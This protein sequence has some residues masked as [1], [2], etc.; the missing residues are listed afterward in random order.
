MVY[1]TVWDGLNSKTT[2]QD[3]TG[4]SSRPG[5]RRPATDHDTFRRL[6]LSSKKST[7]Q[8]PPK[9]E[10]AIDYYNR[11]V[12]A[13]RAGDYTHAVG[14]FD[15]A[16]AL[17]PDVAA[18]YVRRAIARYE[19]GDYAGA[20]ADNS[21][22]IRLKPNDPVAYHNRGFA[23]AQTGN[24]RAAIAD[25]DRAIS[26]KS[27]YANAYRNRGKARAYELDWEGA[28][29]DYLVLVEHGVSDAEVFSWLGEWSSALGRH[30]DALRYLTR[31]VE[32]EPGSA[33]ILA[34]RAQAY[35]RAGNRAAAEADLA[36]AEAITE[37]G[38]ALD[39]GDTLY[40]K[41]AVAAL[42]GRPRAGARSPVPGSGR[43]LAA[44]PLGGA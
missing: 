1:C 4:R 22:A 20:V 16:I 19:L 6:S 8:V 17:A 42:D 31:A 35:A 21:Q 37:P 3:L 29:A 2:A 43:L 40:F 28:V 14:L 10:S 11:G 7:T 39:Q 15:R 9:P 26:L 38:G 27:D 32:I 41:A 13:S 34:Q 44:R 5:R 36:A 18:G 25:Y 33:F 24:A 30:D 23:K 12:D